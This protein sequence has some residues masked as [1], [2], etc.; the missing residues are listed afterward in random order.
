MDDNKRV[1]R[2]SRRSNPNQSCVELSV[3][4][5]ETGIR[6]TKN[7]AGGAIHVGLTAWSAF[8]AMAKNSKPIS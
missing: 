7:R 1:W 2:K 8:L 5:N 4:Q 6:D 3:A